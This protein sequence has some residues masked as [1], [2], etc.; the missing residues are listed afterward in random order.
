M[1]IRILYLFFFFVG[2]SLVFVPKDFDQPHFTQIPIVLESPVK[3]DPKQIACMAKNIF[4][5][6]NGEPILGQAAVARVVM[7]RVNHRFAKTPCDVI[8]QSTGKNENRVCQ[9]SW[10]CAD[11]TPISVNHPAYKRAEKI[12]YEVIV[13]NAYKEVVPNSVLFFHSVFIEPNWSYKYT[14]I[15]GNHIFY[16]RAPRSTAPKVQVDVI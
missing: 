15:I 9:F 12:A 2:I 3:V 16:S 4:Y 1:N 8:Y 6:S 10:V 5:E 14:K 7:N 11:V 13:N